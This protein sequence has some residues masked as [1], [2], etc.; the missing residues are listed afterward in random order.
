MCECE[1]RIEFWNELVRMKVGTR[2]L[3]KLAESLHL[4]FRS[5][6]MQD[7]ME[8][9]ELVEKGAELKLRDE[10]KYRREI[11]GTLEKEKELLA[12]TLGMGWKYRKKI[13]MIKKEVVLRTIDGLQK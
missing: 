3:E 11:K 10:K 6:E 12:E 2:E 8:E 13:K 7:K 5:K 9:R 4:K 1:A